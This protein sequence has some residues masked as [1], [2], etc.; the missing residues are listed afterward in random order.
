MLSTS[1]EIY[2]EERLKEIINVLINCV[3]YKIIE[4][5]A[6]S[7]SKDS[8]GYEKDKNPTKKAKQQGKFCLCQF[9]AVTYLLGYGSMSFD[10]QRSHPIRRHMLYCLMA[11]FALMNLA[12]AMFF[13]CLKVSM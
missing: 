1:D 11:I 5:F 6:F 4:C 9:W 8:Q 10:G 3:D 7:V 12:T 13:L 2:M